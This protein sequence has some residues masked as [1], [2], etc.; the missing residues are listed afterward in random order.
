MIYIG[1]LPTFKW[2]LILIIAKVQIFTIII[3]TLQFSILGACENIHNFML[4]AIAL[5]DSLFHSRLLLEVIW[6]IFLSFIFLC[7]AFHH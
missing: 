7:Y 2:L 4:F 1:C 5:T 6:D 3:R